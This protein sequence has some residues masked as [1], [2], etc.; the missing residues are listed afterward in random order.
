MQ[1]E[2]SKIF[3]TRLALMLAKR[4]REYVRPRIPSRVLRRSLRL[5]A[6]RTSKFRNGAAVEIPHY[7]AVY[8][9]DG[10]RAVRPRQK[11]FIVYF[12]KGQKHLDPR[13]QIGAWYPR[14]I[15]EVKRL[16]RA[17]FYKAVERGDV[18]VTKRSGP[19]KGKHF[20]TVGMRS[21]KPIADRIVRAEVDKWITLSAEQGPLAERRGSARGTIVF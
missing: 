17:Q 14:R 13:V 19:A 4:A 2:D 12:R 5:V 3:L 20:F 6:L 15:S 8:Y 21:F 11:Q 10:H 18:V 1:L 7:W 9:H 16:T